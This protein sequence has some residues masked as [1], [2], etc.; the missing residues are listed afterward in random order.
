MAHAHARVGARELGRHL[1]GAVGRCIVHDQEVGAHRL[2]EDGR[3]ERGQVLALVQ[4]GHDDEQA[5]GHGYLS[6]G[7]A[8]VSKRPN[9]MAT[10]T[11]TM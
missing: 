2:R 3:G 4:R 11:F 5:F 9:R 1:A 8:G 7:T 6:G 10:V